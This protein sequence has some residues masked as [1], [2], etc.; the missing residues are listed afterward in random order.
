MR[1]NDG[2]QT[3]RGIRNLLHVAKRQTI[4]P[5]FPR[6]DVKQLCTHDLTD[7]VWKEQIPLTKHQCG[8]QTEAQQ[9]H[10]NIVFDNKHG[11]KNLP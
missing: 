2:H 11:H 10:I 3:H 8:N 7:S 6:H 9:E 5:D 1:S 4:S